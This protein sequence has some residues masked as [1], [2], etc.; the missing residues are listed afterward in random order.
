MERIAP[1]C[2]IVVIVEFTLELSKIGVVAV[3]IVFHVMLVHIALTYLK[4]IKND[5]H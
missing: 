1:V 3:V 4:R 5:I 2:I